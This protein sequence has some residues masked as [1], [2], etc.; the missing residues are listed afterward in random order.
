MDP[1]N[2]T[3]SKLFVEIKRYPLWAK[4]TLATLAFSAVVIGFI[5]IIS[6][7]SIIFARDPEIHLVNFESQ[8][9]SFQIKLP[10]G[11]VPYESL[12]GIHGDPYLVVQ[13]IEGGLIQPTFDIARV[14][15]PNASLDQIVNWQQ[16]RVKKF[17]NTEIDSVSPY[18][19]PLYQGSLLTYS[20]PEI[21]I[22]KKAV[23]CH[24]WVMYKNPMGYV[25][26]LCTIPEDWTRLHAPFQEMIESFIINN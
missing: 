1:K 17:P 4:I 16:E 8:D 20:N 23:E 14:E 13:A 18:N 6:A 26:S 12:K 3:R 21:G 15:L 9:H 11:W 10:K 2:I 22:E 19:T 25:V 24:D 5:W 7:I